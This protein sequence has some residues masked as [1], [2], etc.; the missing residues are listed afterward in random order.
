MN[1]G[2]NGCLSKSKNGFIKL[3]LFTIFIFSSGFAAAKPPAGSNPTLTISEAVFL[4]EDVGGTLKVDISLNNLKGK[5]QPRI[6]TLYS[7]G[8]S[9]I[10]IS[11][12]TKDKQ[13]TFEISF[14]AG[15]TVPCNVYATSSNPELTT[16]TA[17]VLDCPD[18]GGNHP[19]VCVIEAPA[20]NTSITVGGSI[21]YQS[22]VT[23]SDGN[24][25]QITWNFDG[26]D[27]GT[28]SSE[29]P[30]IV[31]YNSVGVFTTTLNAVDL[32]GLS[33]TQ[34]QRTITVTEDPGSNFVTEPV[35]EQPFLG[36][37]NYKVLA[38]NDLGM[39]CADLDGQIF[40]I[41]PPFNALHA[42]VIHMGAAPVLTTPES[43]PNISVV[44]SAV[45][46][47]LDPVFD[48]GH[49]TMPA[50]D[51]PPAAVLMGT[52]RASVSIN[53]T[54]RNDDSAGV[55]KSN[56][57]LQNPETSNPF[58]FD[59][60]DNIFFGLLSPAAI[61]EDT[62][63]PVPESMLLPDCLTNPPSCM[64]F[65]Q[66]MPGISLPAYTANDPKPFGRFDHDV[67]FF[68][69]VLGPPLGN[70]VHDVNWWAADGIVVLPKDDAGRTNAY[71]LMRVQASNNGSVVASTDVVVPVASEA[72][73]QNC[74]VDPV[75]C[76]L[77]DLPTLIRSENCNGVAVEY[78][79][80]DVVYLSELLDAAFPPGDT[81][82]QRLLNTA[83]VNILR[84]HDVKHGANYPAG[85]GDGSCNAGSNAA[86]AG[87]WN[88]NCLSNSTPIQCS[89]CHY[90]PAL[91]LAQLGP[92]DD[93]GNQVFQVTV[94]KTMSSVMH[95]HHGSLNV[96]GGIWETGQ[97]KLFPDMPPPVSGNPANYRSFNDAEAVLEQTC[98][99]CH[100]GKRTQCLRGAMFSGGVVC[101]DCHG[102]MEDVGEDFT[103]GG[104]RVPWASEP[105]CQSCHTGD[106]LNPNHPA[107][108]LLA[109][110]GIRLLQAFVNDPNSPIQSPGSR[111]A[112]NE[113][114][115]RLSGNETTSAN[116]QGH[117]GIMC[118]GCHGSTHAIWP[119]ANPNAND[120]VAAIQLQGHTGTLTECTACHGD[121]AFS[122]ED[123]EE[124]ENGQMKGP[125]GMHPVNDSMWNEKH[126]EVDKP[127]RNT[128]RSCHG[129]DGEGTVLSRAA[130]DRVLDCKVDNNSN[131]CDNK[132]VSVAKGTEI[133]CGLCHVNHIN[134]R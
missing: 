101:Q 48:P 65:Q 26:G 117:A 106:A 114:L 92:T 64:F 19:P 13:Y 44:Y 31:I 111:F 49:P 72:D 116:P 33:C 85:W 79:S 96:T 16:A 12:S 27:P 133:G 97:T 124:L 126:K 40:S 77:E 98:Y 71:P 99:Q 118:E 95:G 123:F 43:H 62:G 53:S 59:A 128:C 108:A 94:N 63:L 60:Y 41:L 28:S 21:S 74:H 14:G 46:N 131:G 81:L 7:E 78:T 75:D 109:E 67:N 132:K 122:I 69:S 127:G 83:K 130:D 52:N 107:G 105:M 76:N 4:P 15:E 30:G 38:A 91:D 51:N 20:S 47:P 56:F 82:E 32:D 66:E 37:Q 5:S 88:E 17:S 11:G 134:K 45:S 54:S 23:D 121:N 39:H 42:Q 1:I 58:G 50:A 115:Y 112:E 61:T 102:G 73:C 55:F 103:N 84:L 3:V 18:V 89:Q 68:N 110:D 93:P 24:L 119:N 90:S 120:N 8:N 70:I 80:F 25:N 87:S 129:Q 10:S 35:T 125:H 2:S 57:W 9:E 6:Y 36:N 113:S 22:S 86:D 100:P 34:Q 29:D 104:T